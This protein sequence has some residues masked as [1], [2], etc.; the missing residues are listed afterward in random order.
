MSQAALQ[1]RT[2]APGSSQ[3]QVCPHQPNNM[4]SK[5]FSSEW[6]NWNARRNEWNRLNART[7][8]YRRMEQ[9]E[10]ENRALKT[11]MKKIEQ[12]LPDSEDGPDSGAGQVL[13]QADQNANRAR[14]GHAN[15]AMDTQLKDYQ[16]RS[17]HRRNG[18]SH[19]RH[20]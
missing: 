17:K 18:Q 6:N 16:Q 20:R 10:R 4:I 2:Q 5:S 8:Y 12:K 1:L 3:L 15:V 7:I 14:E 19:R 11:N 13:V 9:L